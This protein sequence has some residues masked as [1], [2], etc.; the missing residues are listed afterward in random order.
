MKPK[1]LKKQR[2]IQVIQSQQVFLG[3]KLS[4]EYVDA[5][6]EFSIAWD[7]FEKNAIGAERI[8]A[9]IEPN[10]TQKLVNFM[11]ENRK[12]KLGSFDECRG[13]YQR[14]S[15]SQVIHL[16]QEWKKPRT[17]EEFA[18]IFKNNVRFRWDFEGANSFD[19]LIENYGVFYRAYKDYQMRFLRFYEWLA[20]STNKDNIPQYRGG[21]SKATV[22]LQRMFMKP[23]PADMG[24]IIW[25]TYPLSDQ[26]K[27]TNIKKFIQMHSKVVEQNHELYLQT[28][29][30]NEHL[31]GKT[32][33]ERYESKRE[34]KEGKPKLSQNNLNINV[35]EDNENYEKSFQYLSIKE[36]EEEPRQILHAHFNDSAAKSTDNRKKPCF[37]EML[38]DNGC[39][40]AP[41]DCLCSHKPEDLVAGV[42]NHLKLSLQSKYCLEE[43]RRPSMTAVDG[44]KVELK[45]AGPYVQIV[46]RR[47]NPNYEPPTQIVQRNHNLNNSSK[48]IEGHKYSNGKDVLESSDEYEEH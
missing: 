11:V 36:V 43:N 5:V 26:K 24:D 16:M 30:R 7:A 25:A 14:L 3:K 9:A 34:L 18:R 12:W 46:D 32:S 17:V 40:K 4:S 22:S 33:K 6:I 29:D 10:I 42:T 8:Q 28:R 19:I 44:S 20:E 45:S 47:K 39:T 21:G 41:G 38:Y 27:S 15:S 48:I 13:I 1:S 37:A 31:S 35:Y 2:K 23:M